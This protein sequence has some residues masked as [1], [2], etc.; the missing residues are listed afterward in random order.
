M[1]DLHLVLKLNLRLLHDHGGLFALLFLGLH[2]LDRRGV[3]GLFGLDE[4]AGFQILELL[5]KLGYCD[6]MLFLGVFQ[7]LIVFLHFLYFDSFHSAFGF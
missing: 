6:F 3:L 1:H 2:Q 4:S 7:I 5:L